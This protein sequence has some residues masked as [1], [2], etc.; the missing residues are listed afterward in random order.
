MKTIIAFLRSNYKRMGYASGIE[1]YRADKY[2]KL[3]DSIIEKYGSTVDISD[4]HTRLSRSIDKY[5][6]AITTAYATD[7][8]TKEIVDY[9][10]RFIEKKVEFLVTFSE[11]SQSQ[12]DSDDRSLESIPKIFHELVPDGSS[13][14]G[15]FYDTEEVFS[16]YAEKNNIAI[17]ERSRGTE[18]TKLSKLLKEH[19]GIEVG[20]K[21]LSEVKKTVRCYLLN[22][23]SLKQLELMKDS[24]QPDEGKQPME[25]KNAKVKSRGFRDKGKKI[26]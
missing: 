14:D 1:K 6:R 22:N 10:F 25:R 2:D 21:Y 4:M 11:Q 15:K 12:K 7:E 26:A 16:R 17:T 13:E 24:Q 8:A 23:D 18:K 19:F 5:M 20:P 3:M 9:A